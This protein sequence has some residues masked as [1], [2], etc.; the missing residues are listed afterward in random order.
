M[1]L[2]ECPTIDEYA[3]SAKLTSDQLENLRNLIDGVAER[4]EISLV[5]MGMPLGAWSELYFLFNRIVESG[6]V[7]QTELA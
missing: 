7:G 6:F 5:L 3:H 2:L 1:K 4:K